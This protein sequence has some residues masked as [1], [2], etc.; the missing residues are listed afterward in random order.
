MSP[1]HLRP[2]PILKK[3]RSHTKPTVTPLPF[4]DHGPLSPHV[5]FPPTPGLTSTHAVYSP[6]TYDRAPII[7]SPNVCELPDRHDRM[8]SPPVAEFEIE[9][10]ERGRTKDRGNRNVK[11][12][13]FHPRAYEACEPEPT[14]RTS[15]S[16][17]N[18]PFLIDDESPSEDEDDEIITPP[19]H[20]P[21]HPAPWK[22]KNEEE[23]GPI[24]DDVYVRTPV[25]SIRSAH[26][27]G[28]PWEMTQDGKRRRPSLR[29]MAHQPMMKRARDCSVTSPQFSP[30]LDEGC[31]GGF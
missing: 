16:S 22:R 3:N 2:R 19:D 6:T 4:I 17:L 25:Y 5:H 30:Q 8:Y 7:V 24:L 21:P 23:D 10:I 15:P 14:L 27:Q 11:G 12:S 29:R 31:L 9:H 20:Y 18:P 28:N 26:S 1:N 13:Y